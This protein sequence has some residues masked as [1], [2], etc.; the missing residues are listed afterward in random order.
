MYQR[1]SPMRSPL[2]LSQGFYLSLWNV[3]DLADRADSYRIIA[4]FGIMYIA[5]AWSAKN[6]ADNTII[7]KIMLLF[8]EC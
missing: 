1:K 7:L 2:Q 4:L 3:H 6:I 8:V 5:N